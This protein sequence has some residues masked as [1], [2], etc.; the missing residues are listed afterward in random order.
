MMLTLS[1]F[2]I[3]YHCSLTVLTEQVDIVVDEMD[4]N[5]C[6]IF[7]VPTAGSIFL[8]FF[9]SLL[10]WNVYLFTYEAPFCNPTLLWSKIK[11]TWL[12]VFVA[13]RFRFIEP[14]SSCSSMEI[15][16]LRYNNL[17]CHYLMGVMSGVT[18]VYLWMQLRICSL[19]LLDNVKSW[20]SV[21]QRMVQVATAMEL[22]PLRT[23]FAV[24]V[25]TELVALEGE[26]RQQLAPVMELI[27]AVPPLL[28]V[29]SFY[30]WSK[31]QPLWRWMAALQVEF[32]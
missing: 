8:S 5:Y 9:S 13:N 19:D 23:R 31:Q 25:A 7:V 14:C 21:V 20:D 16:I 26:S 27:A 11:A 32:K 12:K 3:F 30:P 6:F 10:D 17:L 29:H 4:I 2:N 24:D 18:C 1:G 28:G 22:Q 15:Q